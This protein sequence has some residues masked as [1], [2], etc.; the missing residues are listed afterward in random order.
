LGF[1]DR[2]YW[3]TAKPYTDGIKLLVKRVLI[4]TDFGE[5]GLPKWISW[6]K[7]IVDGALFVLF[8]RGGVLIGRYISRQ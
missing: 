1:R 7:A 2:E 3:Q 8:T 5:A 6:L 4:T